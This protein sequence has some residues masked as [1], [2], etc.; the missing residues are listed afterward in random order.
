MKRLYGSIKNINATSQKLKGAL[1]RL[2]Q[3]CGSMSAQSNKVAEFG[4][5]GSFNRM[6]WH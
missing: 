2:N 3:L 4:G 5:G 1:I 6:I